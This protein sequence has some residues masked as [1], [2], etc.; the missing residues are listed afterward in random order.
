MSAQQEFH[1]FHPDLGEGAPPSAS[2]VH[3]VRAGEL[4]RNTAQSGGMTRFAAISGASVGSARIWMGETHVAPSTASENHHH[5]DS[6]TAIYVVSGH[7]SFVF[8]D[9][10]GEVRLDT[11]PGDYVFVPPF[12]PHREENP[13]P[14][15]PAVVVISRSTQEAI[16]VNL[17]ALY[18]LID[19]G[20]QP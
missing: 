20:G 6:E 11:G 17:P 1:G 3:H 16:V 10:A 14:S 4:D 9:G 13:D 8:H 15:D 5:G 7:P 19:P 18:P 2:R 12:V